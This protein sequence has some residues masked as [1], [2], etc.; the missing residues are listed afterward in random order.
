M[1]MFYPSSDQT[2]ST[3]IIIPVLLAASNNLDQWPISR[4]SL[5]LQFQYE[6]LGESRFANALKNMSR[7]GAGDLISTV[8]A[9]SIAAAQEQIDQC[10]GQNSQG[11]TNHHLIVEPTDRGTLNSLLAAA[12][13]SLS[14]NEQA[15]LLIVDTAKHYDWNA[16]HRAIK[17]ITADLSWQENIV[18]FGEPDTTTHTSYSN[19]VIRTTKTSVGHLSHYEEAQEQ[20]GR[21]TFHLGGITLASPRLLINRLQNLHPKSTAQCHQAFKRATKNGNVIWPDHNLWCV[22]EEQDFAKTLVSL[23]NCALLRPIEH[24]SSNITA[25]ASTIL[26]RSENCDVTTTGHLIAIAGCSDLRVV[27]TS[28]ATLIVKHGHE[29]DVTD[30]LM[31]LRKQERTEIFDPKS[32]HYKWGSTNE[33]HA[34]RVFDISQIEIL[35]AQTMP[36]RQH[37]NHSTQWT[38]L[39]GNGDL[40]LGGK[41][42]KITTGTVSRIPNKADHS[43]TNTGTSPL[44]IQQ[45]RL[46]GDRGF[47]TAKSNPIERVSIPQP[48]ILHRHHNTGQQHDERLRKTANAL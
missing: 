17:Q 38:I 33:L 47:A 9:A 3:P 40:I 37:K 36:A 42:H 2:S 14:L 12:L 31:Q 22:L 29:A 11:K 10:L 39:S 28:D 35:P 43:C 27:S 24:I 15:V 8:P 30:I 4:V 48:S 16:V 7:Y 6:R 26:S 13:L 18:A 44:I 34:R 46:I 41:T 20:S 1:T 19:S 5:P 21:S 32:R 45:T 23:A 25:S